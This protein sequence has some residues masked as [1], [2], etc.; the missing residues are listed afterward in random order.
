MA[1][2]SE[3][4]GG[5]R[6]AGRPSPMMSG[7]IAICSRSSRFASRNIETVTPPPSMKILEQPRACSRRTSLGKSTPSCPIVHRH[8]CRAAEVPLPG[9][10]RR[11]G[12]HIQ[13]RRGVVAE[14]TVMLFEPARR[15][16]D[17]AQRARA[18]DVTGRELRVVGGDRAGADDHGITQRTHA[19]H[20]QEILGTGDVLR[21]AGVGRDEPVEALAEMAD[22]DRPGAGGAADRQIQIDRADDGRR[23][24]AGA[25]SQPE[26]RCHA[27]TASSRPQARS[28]RSGPSANSSRSSA[29]SAASAASAA[30]CTMRHAS[31]MP[32][33]IIVFTCCRLSSATQQLNQISRRAGIQK[34]TL[35]R[36]SDSGH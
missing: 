35:I 14:D 31:S 23:R 34:N 28:C 21:L 8:Q 30:A 6:I 19:V 11:T 27:R 12:N 20:V 3:A 13:R 9:R 18:G 36:S 25:A 17:D 26:S 16:E 24:P 32:D 7:A 29:R 5:S 33:R 1:L 4:G 10:G 15:I 2:A 22:R